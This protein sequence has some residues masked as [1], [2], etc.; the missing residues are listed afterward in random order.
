MDNLT[1]KSNTTDMIWFMDKETGLKLEPCEVN[2]HHVRLLLE[3]L[4]YYEE[5]EKQGRL[6]IE[7]E[8]NTTVFVI[9]YKYDCDCN[10]ECCLE[11]DKFK[12]D[13][14]LPCKH[15]TKSLCIHERKYKKELRKSLGITVFLTE[16]EAENRL[17][18]LKNG[19]T[20]ED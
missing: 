20:K 14:D 19:R 18:V 15:E 10:Y 11:F 1:F 7:P 12:C 6:I 3:K 8:E 16:K 13:N 4:S 5:I 2:S 9:E 17:E